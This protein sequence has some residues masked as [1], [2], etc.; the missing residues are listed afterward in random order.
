LLPSIKAE[1]HAT[2]VVEKI[3]AALNGPVAVAGHSLP[4]SASIGVTVYPQ[5]GEDDVALSRHADEAMYR[6]KQGGRNG[7]QMYQVAGESVAEDGV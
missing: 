2:L 1:R 4:M 5:H 6:A 3:R 7:M